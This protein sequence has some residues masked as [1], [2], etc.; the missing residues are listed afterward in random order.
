MSDCPRRQLADRRHHGICIDVVRHVA[1]ACQD[2]E[3][4]VRHRRRDR[5]CMDARRY[6]SVSAA[7]QD[8]GGGG[9]LAIARRLRGNE[10]L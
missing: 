3:T 7:C 1:D 9:D 5:A 2:D 4:R 8:H 10:R 6:R